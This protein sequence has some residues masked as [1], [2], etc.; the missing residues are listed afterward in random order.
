MKLLATY[1][2]PTVCYQISNFPTFSIFYLWNVP[3]KLEG[4]KQLEETRGK[5]VPYYRLHWGFDIIQY[6]TSRD[7]IPVCKGS[8]KKDESFTLFQI[9]PFA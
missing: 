5:N 4:K 9:K 2:A 8:I 1:Q 7:V 6:S 3:R